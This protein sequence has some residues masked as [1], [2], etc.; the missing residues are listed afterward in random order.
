MIGKPNA[1]VFPVPVRA[2]TTRLFPRTAGSTTACWTGVG[3]LYPMASM[4]RRTSALSGSASNVG[5]VAGA[6]GPLCVAG[7]EPSA[8]VVCWVMEF[9][10]RVVLSINAADKLARR[11]EEEQFP[12]PA[13]VRNLRPLGE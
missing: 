4:A 10:A 8:D 6:V 3:C 1:H 5:A 12:R 13:C 2:W 9:R 11:G 7:L